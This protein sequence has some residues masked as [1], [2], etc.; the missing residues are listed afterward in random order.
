MKPLDVQYENK[1]L[2]KIKKGLLSS[3]NIKHVADFE[4]DDKIELECVRIS[5][6]R[7]ADCFE[8]DVNID[9]LIEKYDDNVIDNLFICF[10]QHL[11]DAIIEK[12]EKRGG[13]KQASVCIKTLKI[14]VTS[15][16]DIF[17]KVPIGFLF[18]IS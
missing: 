9:K 10:S 16:N 11:V 2:E 3:R 6:F 12:I 15:E 14:F 4:K 13:K 8:D 18:V 1:L 17:C 7:R 5:F